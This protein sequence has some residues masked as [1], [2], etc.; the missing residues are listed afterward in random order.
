MAFRFPK[1][2][3]RKGF[4]R[5]YVVLAVG[6]ITTVLIALPSYRIRF[7][8]KTIDYDALAQQA[9][10]RNPVDP[11]DAIAAKYGG[12]DSPADLQTFDVEGARRA[13]AS[14]DDILKHLTQ[15]RGFDVQGAL[16]AGATKQGIITHL[17][18]VRPKPTDSRSSGI[19][20]ESRLGKLLYLLSLLFGPPVGAYLCCFLVV[21]WIFRGFR[22][23]VV[24]QDPE[25][26]S[27][28]SVL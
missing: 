8:E 3:Y 20:E 22:L 6:W 25:G 18:T 27:Q 28:T 13:G 26:V 14:D 1:L 19:P 5:L 12:V 9:R 15:T 17:S 21:P 24:S 11:I 16:K 7:W 4:T 10:D 2:N 23:T